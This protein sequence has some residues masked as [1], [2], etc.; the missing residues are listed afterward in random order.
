[1]TNQAKVKAQWRMAV[2]VIL[3]SLCGLRAVAAQSPRAEQED[4]TRRLWNK[5]CEAA[6]ARIKKTT[7]KGQAP[8]AIPPAAAQPKA[9]SGAT[10]PGAPSAQA[11]GGELIGVTFWRLRAATASDD[12]SKPRLLV[13]NA[14]G[15][16]LLERVEADTPFSEGQLVRLSLEVPPAGD[17]YLYVIDREVYADGKRGDPRL[18]FPSQS[19][20]LA[21]TS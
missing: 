14:P 20:P 16:Y 18:I 8:A 17:S 5:Q 13:Q 3:L 6:R 10:A 12:Q 21:A 7:A 15:P 19:T 9:K 11:V 4:S 2:M 1:M